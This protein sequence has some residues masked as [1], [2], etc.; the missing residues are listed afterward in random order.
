MIYFAIGTLLLFVLTMVC[1]SVAHF[2][3]DPTFDSFLLIFIG[4]IFAIITATMLVCNCL[5][6]YNWVSASVKADII[7]KEYG[8]KYSTSEVFYGSDVIDKIQQI[9][10]KRI[11]VNGNLFGG[12]DK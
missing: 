3:D 11:E 8:T 10:R 12:G 4:V 2:N 6:G 5:M 9:K 7:N 1:F